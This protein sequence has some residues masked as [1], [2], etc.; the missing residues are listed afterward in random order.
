M[1]IS[2]MPSS[3]S[4]WAAVEA[5]NGR[6]PRSLQ[7]QL[8]ASDTVCER[9][10]AYIL[11]GHPK[12]DHV[13]SRAA[14]LGTMA[15]EGLTRAAKD[16]FGWLIERK[17]ADPAIRG[18][19]DIVQLDAA[20]AKRLPA[21][22][23]PKVAADVVTVEDIKTKTV[24]KW[25][26]VLR[27]GP[28]EAELRQVHLY[29]DL[30]RTD[31]FEDRTGQRVLARLGPVAVEQIRL[32]YVC[33]DNGDEYVH[34]IPFDPQRAEEARWWLTRV[35]ETKRPEEGRRDF[36]GPG[37]DA[38]CDFCPFATACWGIPAP[39]RPAQTTLIHDDKDVEQALIDYVEAHKPFAE[40]KRIKDF[41]RKKL[42]ASKA[43]QYGPNI[44]K[45]GGENPVEEPDVTKMIELFDDA[46][47]KVPQTEDLAKMVKILKA[48]G[49]P[50][51]MRDTGRSSAR[52]IRVVPYRE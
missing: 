49:L 32:R 52:T 44:L 18:S 46:G 29:A 48:A 33:R 50:V 9:R 34:E 19:I 41:A 40:A 13:F 16:E 23:R 47:L 22:L 38:A 39:G 43:G 8:G 7:V 31:G 14:A 21:R 28:T 30:L 27:Y 6:R 20:T 45:W 5:A 42:D 12:T 25:D 10:A 2:A 1:S 51:P 37:L 11:H 26:D 17:V 24:W 4:I 15:H 35:A 3:P 36:L